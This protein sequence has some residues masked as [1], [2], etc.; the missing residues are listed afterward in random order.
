MRSIALYSETILENFRIIFSPD[1]TESPS[2]LPIVIEWIS[3]VTTN[4]TDLQ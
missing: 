4:D 1:P 2:M 3:V